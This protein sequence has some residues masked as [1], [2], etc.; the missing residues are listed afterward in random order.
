MDRLP[1]STMLYG[2]DREI[3]RMLESLERI[4]SGHGEILLVPGSSGVGKTALVHELRKPVLEKNGFFIRGKFEQYQQDVPYFA[5]RQALAELCLELQTSTLQSTRFKDDILL[6]I[7]N[8]GQVLVNLVP[9]FESFLGEQPPLENIS[10][11]EARHRFAG[12]FQKLLKVI[13]RPEHPLVLFI[14]DWQWADTASCELLR[15]IQVGSTLRYLLV[16]VSYRDNEVDSGHPL[17]ASINDL[18]SHAVA[19]EVLQV[20]NITPDDV[21]ELVADTLKSPTENVAELAAIIHG[22]TLGNP[23]FVR[24]FLGFLHEDNRVWFD[25]DRNCWQWRLENIGGAD[26]PKNLVDLF[27]QK[28][29]RLDNDRRNIFSLAACLGNR[30]DLETLSIISGRDPG[31]CRALLFSDPAKEMLL[32]FEGVESPPGSKDF[33]PRSRVCTFLHDKV[34]KAAF[35]LI[36]PT[37]LPAILLKIGRLLLAS[38]PPEQLDNRLFEVVTDLNAGRHLILDPAEQIEVLELNI[39]AARKAYM[40]SAYHSALQYYRAAGLFLEAPG[41]A[42]DLW[43]GRH[44]LAMRLFKGRAECE[45]LEGD[46]NTA[47]TWI[48]QSITHAETAL[49]K[50]DVFTILIVQYTLLARYPEA[51]AAGREALEALGIS[52]PRDGYEEARNLEIAQVRR[53]L[54]GRSVPSLVELPLM[55]NPEMLMASKILITIGPPCYRSDQRLWSVIVPKAINLIL[56]YGN[57]PQV[58]YSHTAFGGLL[59]WVD[60]DYATAKEFGELATRLMTSTFQSPADQSVFY[61]M[62]GSSIRHWFKHLSLGT[63]DYMEAYDIGLRSGNLQYAAYAFGHNMYCRFYQGVPLEDL[64]KETQ[65][66]LEFSRTRFNQWAIDLLEGGLHVFQ[67]LSGERPVAKGNDTWSDE[68][69]FERLQAH[70]NIQVSCIYKILTTFALLLSGK[71]DDALILSDETEPLIYTVG[72][73]GLL[74]WPE[75]LF[76]R[77]LILTSLYAKVDGKRQTEWRSALTLML[78]KLRIWADNCPENFEHKYLLAAA[79]LARIDGRPLA[80]IQLY[81]TAIEAAQ[82][83]AFLQWE[84]MANERAHRFWLEYGNERL[85]H[86]YWHQAYVCYSRWGAISKVRL[87]E[88]EYRT[89]LAGCLP[90]CE[91]TGNPVEEFET[92]SANVLAERHIKLLRNHVLQ[93]QQSRL[94]IEAEKEA[95]E[96]AEAMERVRTETAERKHAEEELHRYSGELEKKNKELQEALAKVKQLTGMLPICASCNKIREDSGYWSGVET[97]LSEHTDAVFSHGLCPECEKKG[98]EDLAQLIRENK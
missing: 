93:I 74:P 96:L 73:Q 37:E 78:G 13:C 77:L 7:G 49:E 3:N 90:G 60:N 56:H 8:L 95:K 39:A 82:S 65:L 12:V 11:Q 30:F 20:K 68:A 9:E 76:V 41:F 43:R 94:R 86:V 24:S 47:E 55:S 23:F 17:L 97:Y 42:E 29:R 36:D 19:V 15:R 66:A 28:L 26:L 51:I 25:K 59:G 50:A 85:A 71:H 46:R 40:A 16:I 92:R 64:I 6:A 88:A 67:A 58:G 62:I 52:L 89:Y 1:I 27:V 75:H 5:I 35:S 61:L 84:G 91:E 21:L 79:E 14:D 2:R 69:Y 53:E 54:A 31:E 33:V 45:F 63:Q 87:M 4:S 98:H 81:D 44:E 18:R 10:P 72:T 32:V 48:Q 80:A 57:I 70:N 83:G 22:K 34:Q 38:L